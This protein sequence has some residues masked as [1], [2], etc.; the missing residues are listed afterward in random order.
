MAALNFPSA[1]SVND[2]YTANGRTWIWDG[3]T[4]LGYNSVYLATILAAYLPLAG[5]TMSGPINMGN[6][7]VLFTRALAFN[8]IIDD[9]TISASTKTIDFTIGQFHK[10]VMA[11]NLVT[12]TLT[13]PAGPGVVH[14]QLTQD[15]TGARSMQLPTGTWPG[16]YLF[17]EK[18]L[19]I[20][21]SA[22]DLLTLRW[23]G[24]AWKYT[25]AKGWAA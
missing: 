18:I 20:A 10:A 16:S 15:G 22:V 23:D 17:S 19:S 9:G 2:L 12:F 4:W 5:G 7:D 21:P 14:L 25:L 13:P 8:S 24:S 6:K 3:A 11:N 1:P